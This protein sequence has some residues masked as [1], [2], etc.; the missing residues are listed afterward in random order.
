MTIEE[1]LS[2]FLEAFRVVSIEKCP[3]FLTSNSHFLGIVPGHNLDLLQ[4]SFDFKVDRWSLLK[5]NIPDI[6]KD[7]SKAELTLLKDDE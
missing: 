2:E 4:I 1:E 5:K 7:P 6:L 3:S